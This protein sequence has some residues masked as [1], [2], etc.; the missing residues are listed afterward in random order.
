M[1]KTITN[2][3]RE[4]REERMKL[5]SQPKRWTQE[6]IA[7]IVGVSRQTIIAIEKGRYNPSLLLAFKIAQVFDLKIEEIFAYG[8]NMNEK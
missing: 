1:V 5:S 2:Q 7:K 4:I 3:L 8:G 6:E